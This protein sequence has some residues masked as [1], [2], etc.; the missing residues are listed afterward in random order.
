MKKILV[1]LAC[2][3]LAVMAQKTY[4]TKTAKIKFFSHTPAEDIQA[5][6]SQV[7]SK[8]VDKTGALSF[9]MLM[10]GFVFEN[11]LMQEHFNGKDYLNSPAFPKATFT[12]NIT[13]IAAVNFAKNGKYNV[14]VS[15][16][17]TIKGKTQKTTAT[18]TITVNNGKLVATSVFKIK[19]KDFGIN[20]SEEIAEVIEI[21]V[22]ANY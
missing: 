19:L 12:G 5:T 8:L 6:N 21:T 20:V 11:A 10:K 15:G 18:G 13:N 22:T 17:L 2:M 4:S 3:P 1:L 9:V 7:E 16:N 14:T